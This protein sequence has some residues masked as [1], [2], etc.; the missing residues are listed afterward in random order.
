LCAIRYSHGRSGALRRPSRSATSA[1]VKV[2]WSASWASA[3]LRKI[4]WQYLYSG[5]R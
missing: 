4:E 1:F 5:W 3:S 2:D